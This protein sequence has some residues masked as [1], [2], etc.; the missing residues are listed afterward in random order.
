MQLYFKTLSGKTITLE[1]EKTET[2]F[3]VKQKL[4][5]KIHEDGCN[6]ELKEDFAKLEYL[7]IIF[8][9]KICPDDIS[10]SEV[11]H[12]YETFNLVKVNLEKKDHQ[13]IGKASIMIAQGSRTNNN[14]T[15][16][17]LCFFSQVPNE[18]NNKIIAASAIHVSQADA[19]KF[20]SAEFEKA[21]TEHSKYQQQYKMKKDIWLNSVY[22]LFEIISNIVKNDS[23]QVNG[24]D[25]CHLGS[26]L[27]AFRKGNYETLKENPEDFGIPNN[28]FHAANEYIQRNPFL[29]N[30][31]FISYEDIKNVE[32]ALTKNSLEPF[33][34][35]VAQKKQEQETSE[36]NN[37]C[38][39]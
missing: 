17:K 12:S 34:D 19:L 35:F 36:R 11:N 28:I 10:I 8:A 15:D 27:L 25:F 1:L 30:K 23:A 20:A 31:N 29:T 37:C 38:I 24:A 22:G 5:N 21:N 18:L 39:S 13:E 14:L 6:T 26:F 32:V 16:N 9:G 4:F 3:Q 2:F 33:K 7:R